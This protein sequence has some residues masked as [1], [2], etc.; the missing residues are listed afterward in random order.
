MYN[1]PQL[2]YDPTRLTQPFIQIQL[3][4]PPYTPSVPAIPSV[5]QNLPLITSMV[6]MEIQQKAQVNALRMFMFNQFAQNSFCTPD[7]DSLVD[8]CVRYIELMLAKRQFSSIEEAIAECV[9]RTVEMI[10]AVALQANPGLEQ[11]ADPHTTQVAGRLIHLFRQIGDEINAMRNSQQGGG[12]QR[13]VQTQF[14][15][16]GGTPYGNAYGGQ[17]Q[18]QI[19][20]G[21]SHGGYSAVVAP[22]TRGTTSTGGLFSSGTQAPPT[23]SN[24][25][26]SS[27]YGSASRYALTNQQEPA[28]EVQTRP[29][30]LQ[31]PFTPRSSQEIDSMQQQNNQ[32]NVLDEPTSA[33]TTIPYKEM[34]FVWTPRHPYF[35]AFAPSKFDMS[36]KLQPDGTAVPFIKRKSEEQILD[37][38]KHAISTVFGNVPKK[39]EVNKHLEMLDRVQRG[40]LTMK[41][42]QQGAAGESQEVSLDD[43]AAPVPDPKVTFVL[44][45]WLSE[46]SLDAAWVVAEIERNKRNLEAQALPDIFRVYVEVNAVVASDRDELALVRT[47]SEAKTFLQLRNAVNM[48]INDMSAQLYGE[49][50]KRLTDTVNRILAQNLSMTGVRIDSFADDIED[51][52]NVLDNNYGEVVVSAFLR[53]QAEHIVAVLH[54]PDDEHAKTMTENLLEAHF[55]EGQAHPAITYVGSSYSL[56]LLNVISYA[57]DVELNKKG[58]AMLSQVLT[59]MLYDLVAT[60]FEEASS[61]ARANFP[62]DRHLIRTA[63]GRVLEASRGYIGEAAN[64][65]FYLLTLVE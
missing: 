47:L 51:L 38:D 36:Y 49:V 16:G 39:L 32:G 24:S 46:H 5:A 27:R 65:K 7:L 2:R 9:P 6:I 54:A 17:P 23:S 1:Q 33:P 12:F 31:Q 56:T 11:Y 41:N 18:M 29:A 28:I 34:E 13:P 45:P 60:L 15:T 19:H 21:G 30:T 35:P 53:H 43:L 22:V 50:N 58:S 44:E 14:N 63:D 64:Q 48:H 3:G 59:P 57:L 26:T 62:V 55:E 52:I 42:A 20:R 25:D 8:A 4:Y 40:V 61:E 10:C 37:Y